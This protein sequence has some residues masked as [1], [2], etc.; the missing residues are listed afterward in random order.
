MS[1]LFTHMLSQRI[2]D[3]SE[4]SD[5]LSQTQF[6]YK[7]GYNTTD[8]TFVLNTTLSFC[9]ETFKHSCCG[10]NDFSKAFDKID[11]ETYIMGN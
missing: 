9:I 8:A 1:K 4:E 6:A 5:I 10:F 3:W 11:R 7:K 2:N